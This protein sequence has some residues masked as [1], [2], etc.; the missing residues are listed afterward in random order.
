MA[1][2]AMPLPL[3]LR[4]GVPIYVTEEVLKKKGSENIDTL[5]RKTQAQRFWTGRKLN[6]PFYLKENMV[7]V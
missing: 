5:A 6:L 1:A 4:M 7:Q 3:A 2:P